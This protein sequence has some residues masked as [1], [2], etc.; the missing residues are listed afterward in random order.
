MSTPSQHL[1]VEIKL[2]LTAV[3]Q[4]REM[5][6]PMGFTL[7]DP[8]QFEHN[9]LFDTSGRT[10]ASAGRLLRLRRYGEKN[11]ITF[12]RPAG[13]GQPDVDY[14]VKEEIESGFEHFENM[15]TILWE[16]GYRTVWIYEKFRETWSRDGVTVFLDE[17][18]IGD[19]VEIEGTK[20]EIDRLAGELGYS[21]EDYIAVNY[22]RLWV[23]AGKSG[24][25]T[26]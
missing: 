2:K 7:Q 9:I 5:L 24:D 26:F 12:K 11:V 16:L 14:K 4:M 19:F 13:D 20:E 15:K 1:E 6:P 21:K 3:S 10:L 23:K 22:R 8:R 17:T 18:P 25:M